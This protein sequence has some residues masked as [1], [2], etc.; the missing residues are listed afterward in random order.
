LV[1][2]RVIH[3]LESKDTEARKARC[4]VCGPVRILPAGRGW[5]CAVKKREQK[6]EWSRANADRVRASRQRQGAHRLSCLDTINRAARCAVCGGV[7]IVPWGRGFT[8]GNRAR[9]LRKVQQ[10]APT[11][12]CPTCNDW[13]PWRDCALVP[14]KTLD[15][16]MPREIVTYDGALEVLVRTGMRELPEDRR[17]RTVP[18]L[19]TIGDYNQVSPEWLWALAPNP[20]W[21]R[22]DA[23]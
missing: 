12:R 23:M 16:V 22:L 8:C 5:V 4:S 9:E 21:S 7:D 10:E 13:H 20:D 11:P 1:S 14:Y 2:E 18:G 15:Q 3:H 19:K 17:D 6:R